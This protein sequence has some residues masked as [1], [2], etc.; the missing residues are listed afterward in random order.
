MENRILHRRDGLILTAIEVL[1][2]LG[3]QGLSV[4]EIAKR[5]GISNASIFSHFKTKTDLMIAVLDH[6]TQYDGAILQAIELRRLR[7]TEA[8]RAYIE[9]Y[10]S[11]YENYPAITSII[12]AYDSLRAEKELSAYIERIIRNRGKVMKRLIEEAQAGL[13]IRSEIDGE[14]LAEI[15]MGTCRM[16]CLKWRFAGFE[17]PLMER[18]RTALDSILGA[19]SIH[20]GQEPG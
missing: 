15:I 17:F 8:I 3:Y 5:Q 12:T 20:T 6:Y 11:Y 4:R 10:F 18:I 14:C 9:A 13:E 19:Y 7:G 16:I 2:E 1:N